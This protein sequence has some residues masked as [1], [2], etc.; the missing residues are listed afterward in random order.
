MAKIFKALVEAIRVALCWHPG[1]FVVEASETVVPEWGRLYRCLR[2]GKAFHYSQRRCRHSQIV[3]DGQVIGGD[4]KNVFGGPIRLH[5]C[6]RCGK[7]L[8]EKVE[9]RNG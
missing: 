4:A 8:V 6:I 7:Q 5:T 2:C 3:T 9:A 1:E